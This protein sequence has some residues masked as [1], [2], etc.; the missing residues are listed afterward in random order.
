MIDDID[1]PFQ[2]CVAQRRGAIVKPQFSRRSLVVGI[3]VLAALMCQ[4]CCPLTEI[5]WAQSTRRNVGYGYAETTDIVPMGAYDIAGGSHFSQRPSIPPWRNIDENSALDRYRQSP[6]TQ[7]VESRRESPWLA[8]NSCSF[9]EPGRQPLDSP[10]GQRAKARPLPL[11]ENPTAVPIRGFTRQRATSERPSEMIG[12][13]PPLRPSGVQSL[14]DAKSAVGDGPKSTLNG[15]KGL[16][17]PAIVLRS[18]QPPFPDAI[19]SGYE[20]AV[21]PTSHE[22]GNSPKLQEGNSPKLLR[23]GHVPE[24][25]SPEVVLPA[26]NR[27][28]RD[29][30]IDWG[31]YY[32]QSKCGDPRKPEPRVLGDLIR[33]HRAVHVSKGY[34]TQMVLYDFDFV[35]DTADLKHRGRQQLRMIVSLLPRTF[36]PLVIEET[37]NRPHLAEARRAAVLLELTGGPFPVPEQRVRVGPP[38]TPGLDG[39]DAAL[40][41]SNFRAQTQQRGVSFGGG[42]ASGT[43]QTGGTE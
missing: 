10:A 18:L 11:D 21:I 36:A 1:D 16:R 34:A 3:S 12:E 33:A 14:A 17:Y 23:G 13:Y 41:E 20:S 22:E 25:T 31:C 15:T 4:L 43:S 42:S 37:P 32:R 39:T 27:G 2:T 26:E 8:E 9:T 7:P 38:P 19:R 24:D 5:V 40:I 29:L 35:Q 30:G 6:Q 28:R